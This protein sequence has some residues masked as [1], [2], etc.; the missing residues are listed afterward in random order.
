MAF[1]SKVFV[2]DL[3]EAHSCVGSIQTESYWAIQQLQN[4]R[5]VCRTF[6]LQSLCQLLTKWWLKWV[7]GHN[8]DWANAKG[9]K[10]VTGYWEGSTTEAILIKKSR[11]PIN[12]DSGLLLP[13]VWNPFLLNTPLL[14]HPP[15]WCFSAPVY[16]IHF[17]WSVSCLFN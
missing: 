3:V 10:M 2:A 14:L 16:S 8:I 9:V 11:E 13:S 12:L 4:T 17:L 1:V 15:S 5:R 7:T 6:R